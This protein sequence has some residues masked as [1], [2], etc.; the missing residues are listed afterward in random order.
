MSQSLSPLDRSW[1]ILEKPDAPMHV[2]G[3]ITF[4]KP[5]GAPADYLSDLVQRFREDHG[6]VPPWSFKLSPGLSGKV[7]PS[8]VED[9]SLDLDYHFR[10]SAL[11]R[12]GG[13]REL[14]YSSSACTATPWT[15]HVRCGRSTSSRG[16]RA[17]GS[18]STGRSI[19]PWSTA[20]APC[21]SCSGC[22]E[23]RGAPALW[24][25][26]PEARPDTPH[27]KKPKKAQPAGPK[28]LAAAMRRLIHAARDDQDP[29]LPPYSS[30]RSALSGPMT[31]QRRFATQ[32]IGLQRVKDL[33]TA[34]E[35]TVNDI[36]LTC[37]AP[38]FVAT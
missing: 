25:I 10:H 3:M 30:P 24:T 13:E 23:H 1:L 19:T 16:W 11:P 33:A 15:W 38:G 12:P 9:T 8:W 31:G 2:G 35:G 26:G 28:S 27:A 22:P 6:F 34:A 4:S 21:G 32:Q 7:S 36:V 29:L 17:T 14:A 37:A 18:R 20:P 5:D